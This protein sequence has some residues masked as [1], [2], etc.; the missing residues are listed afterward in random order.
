[1]IVIMTL[2]PPFATGETF[3]V[4]FVVTAI[5]CSPL[6]S[7]C[8]FSSDHCW[9]SFSFCFCNRYSFSVNVSVR[10]R[11]VYLALL[12][13]MRLDFHTNRFFLPVLNVVQRVHCSIR[14][15]R[16]NRYPRNHHH[17]SPEDVRT[18]PN[19]SHHST[20]QNHL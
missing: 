7:S 12:Y 9:H 1:M 6:H 18:L 10:L 3:D 14:G 2:V 13:C 20:R 5:V 19:Q 4:T 16:A 8:L 17:K 11:H 15:R